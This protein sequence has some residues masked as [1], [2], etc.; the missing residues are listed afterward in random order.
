[1]HVQTYAQVPIYSYLYEQND[2]TGLEGLVLCFNLRS[3]VVDGVVRGL[4]GLI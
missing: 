3:S 2:D 4:E 1:M